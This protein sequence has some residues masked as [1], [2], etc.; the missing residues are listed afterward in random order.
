MGWGWGLR[1]RRGTGGGPTPRGPAPSPSNTH[2]S[3]AP[4]AHHDSALHAHDVVAAAGLIDRLQAAIVQLHAKPQAVHH[5]AAAHATV[6]HA[7]AME[8]G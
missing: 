1:V 3:P 7:A 6:G 4:G 8:R 5:I 2:D